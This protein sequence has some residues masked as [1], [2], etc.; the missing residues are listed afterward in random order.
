[1]RRRFYFIE[2]LSRERIRNW[3]YSTK[4]HVIW[5]SLHP[6]IY[7]TRNPRKGQASLPDLFRIQTRGVHIV[8]GQV[9]SQPTRELLREVM[10]HAELIGCRIHLSN[11]FIMLCFICIFSCS[12]SIS[13]NTTSRKPQQPAADYRRPIGHTRRI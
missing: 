4:P 13:L 1:M 7:I 10:V 3:A 6:Q 12:A 8:G 5:L 2:H 11:S 9:S